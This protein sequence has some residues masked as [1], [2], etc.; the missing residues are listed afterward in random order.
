V[1]R[2]EPPIGRY[3]DRWGAGN[4]ARRG[5]PSPGENEAAVPVE[6]GDL[7]ILLLHAR[8]LVVERSRLDDMLGGLAALLSSRFEVT[9]I[10]FRLYDPVADELEIAG[11]WSISP[12][13]LGVGTRLPVRST[14]LAEIERHGGA[15]LSR[16]TPPEDWS[17]LERVLRDEGNRAWTTVPIWRDRRVVALFTISTAREAS[18]AEADLPLFEALCEAVGGQLLEAAA[19]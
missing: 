11:A 7:E 2:V 8:R 4:L 12:T 3:E 1:G 17:L 15:M 19:G 5:H 16:S 6:A 10:S 13:E 18:L 9:R 14:S